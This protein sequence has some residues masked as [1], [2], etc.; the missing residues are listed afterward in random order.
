MKAG[1]LNDLSRLLTLATLLVLTGAC[2][3]PY[4]PRDPEEVQAGLAVP[5][6]REPQD[7]APPS[8]EPAPVASPSPATPSP[9]TLEPV[10]VP[11]SVV[12]ETPSRGDSK[13]FVVWESN[14]TG[15]WRLWT[16]PLAGDSPRQ[17]TAD[18]PGRQHCC[19][20][21]SPDGTGLVYLSLPSGQE[22]YPEDGARGPLRWITPDGNEEKVL[23]DEA[24]T[25]SEHR[26]AIW[27]D[28]NIL[29]YIGADQRT[30]RLDLRDLSTQ[31]LTAPPDDKLD[32][33]WLINRTRTHAT[34]GRPAFAVY[35]D[36]DQRVLPRPYLGGCQPYFSF[37]G[38]W[39]YWTAGPGGPIRAMNLATRD[40]SK[41]EVITMLDKSDASLPPDQGYLYFPMLSA[42]Q[43]LLAVGASRDEHSHH[44]ADYD[45]FVVETD[46]N[47]LAVLSQ[48][49]R[50]TEH[51][52]TDRFPDVWA[53]SRD[54]R[55]L[56]AAPLVVEEEE[57]ADGWPV[58]RRDLIFL[59]EN[60]GGQSKSG[61][62][63]LTGATRFAVLT[64]RGRAFYDR[65][66]ALELRGG[67]VEVDTVSMQG[68]LEGARK[69]NEIT[70]EALVTPT[71]AEQ[72][73]WILTFST[74]NRERNFSLGQE[75]DQLVFQIR[76]TGRPRNGVAVRIGQVSP[77]KA[78]HLVITYTPGELT[79]WLDGEQVSVT[80]EIKSGFFQWRPRALLLGNESRNVE[81][82]WHG[83][84]ENIAIY[85][86]VLSEGDIIANDGFVRQ[87]LAQHEAAVTLPM[88]AKLLRRAPIP[89]LAEISPYRDALA[90]YEYQ[91]T[92]TGSGALAGK[93][94]RVVHRVLVDGERLPIADRRRDD[95]YSLRLEPFADQRQ[96]ESWYLS[97]L[98]GNAAGELY[99]SPAI[100]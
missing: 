24:W 6:D 65:F 45:I 48:A 55:L 69:T 61:G 68:L 43:R 59:W 33:G 2:E 91:V 51:P 42:D 60:D 53:P 30:R 90:V 98:E 73:G 36:D 18:E 40:S 41:R 85:N 32:H 31:E 9:P 5:Q 27:H 21:I 83:R 82:P 7:G 4:A 19:P 89:T 52:A 95:V 16:R 49:Q 10:D 94:I 12:A 97:D 56:A 62:T 75:G 22:K 57:A 67:R 74:G 35:S 76:T 17:L 15:D 93:T 70:I 63:P 37:D 66:G 96:L 23:A 1:A 39:G 78:V 87:S 92:E 26:S 46:P 38:R 14:R 77:E 99:F 79:A 84:V 72:N 11:P 88:R 58:R 64:P 71:L 80:D 3:S 20:H 28:E 100:L 50:I 13:G 54:G 25:Y 29:L 44:T 8:V 34:S 47:T 86:R 81:R